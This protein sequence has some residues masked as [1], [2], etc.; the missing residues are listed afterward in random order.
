[1]Q[2]WACLI[3]GT[4][5]HLPWKLERKLGLLRAQHHRFLLDISTILDFFPPV[6]W[7]RV[8]QS[9]L[10]DSASLVIYLVLGILCLSLLSS[11]TGRE[12]CHTNARHLST[13]PCASAASTLHAELCPWLHQEFLECSRCGVL[14][15]EHV[16]GSRRSW[17]TIAVW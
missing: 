8:S 3:D 5:C 12:S 10:T 1:M 17:S 2:R 14:D 4:Q 7:G 13:C 6:Y 16:E 11:G 9:Q 15:S